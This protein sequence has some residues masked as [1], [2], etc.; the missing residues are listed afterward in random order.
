MTQDITQAV[1]DDEAPEAPQRWYFTFGSGQHLYAG[2]RDHERIQGEG[3]PLDGCYVV[4]YGT[5]MG[6]RAKMIELFGKI[7]CDQYEEL[8]LGPWPPWKL[9]DLAELMGVG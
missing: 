1:P 7:W 4:M 5:F 8:P 3:I 6:T 9:L 2:A